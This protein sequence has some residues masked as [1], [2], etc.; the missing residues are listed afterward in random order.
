MPLS[1]SLNISWGRLVDPRSTILSGGP[2]TVVPC[3][4]HLCYNTDFVANRTFTWQSDPYTWQSDPFAFA[5]NG[6]GKSD[7]SKDT[8][9]DY[10]AIAAEWPMTVGGRS[11]LCWIADDVVKPVHK[12]KSTVS[13]I[14]WRCPAYQ[15]RANKRLRKVRC[16]CQPH[17]IMVQCIPLFPRLFSWIQRNR[18]HTSKIVFFHETTDKIE[19]VSLPHFTLFSVNGSSRS[20][21]TILREG[22][23]GHFKYF[24][25]RK[26]SEAVKQ[27]YWRG[28]NAHSTPLSS[29]IRRH[30]NRHC[31]SKLMY[32]IQLPSF[33]SPTAGHRIQTHSDFYYGNKWSVAQFMESLPEDSSRCLD[34]RKNTLFH[35]RQL[36]QRELLW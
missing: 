23:G 8:F 32:D 25:P 29:W 15:P 17:V 4:T 3:K 1:Q 30:K 21:A 9:V 27:L 31:I 13:A 20:A 26:V 22:G 16:H 5:V 14:K 36:L 12:A 2:R 6:A 7:T 10:S 28:A 34:R 35:K 24:S 19:S 18:R 11:A 33:H